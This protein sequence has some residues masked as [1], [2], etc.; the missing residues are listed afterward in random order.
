[1]DY[2]TM[3]VTKSDQEARLASI[4]GDNPIPDPNILYRANVPSDD[5]VTLAIPTPLTPT[6]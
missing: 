3:P 4:V 6:E 1:M 5:V 2:A